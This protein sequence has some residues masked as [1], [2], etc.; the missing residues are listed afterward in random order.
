MEICYTFYRWDSKM[1]FRD[2]I[3]FFFL[4]NLNRLILGSFLFHFDEQ[5]QAK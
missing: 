5:Q 1:Q 3:F 4:H 2:S